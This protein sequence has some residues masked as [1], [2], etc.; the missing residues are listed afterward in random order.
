MNAKQYLKQL[1][2]L[3]SLIDTKQDQIQS[4]RDM[5]TRITPNYSS[6]SVQTSGVSDK[7]GNSVA[8][9]IDLEKELE[10]DIEKLTNL[11]AEIIYK[12][13][14]LPDAE[15]QKVLTY[16]YISFH[17]WEQIAEKM[18]CSLRWVYELHKRALSAF[19]VVL[20]LS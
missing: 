18:E 11:S 20:K 6:E 8:K 13:N 12:V 4:L 5:T 9:I 17:T 15:L 14:L 19:E 16:K 1:K 10:T 2:W 7:I 3:K